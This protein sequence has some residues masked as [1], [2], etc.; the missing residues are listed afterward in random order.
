MKYGLVIYK[1]TDN[2]GDDIL[3]YAAS[4]F[5]P[6]VDYIIDREQLDIFA[7]IEKEKVSV[8]MNGWFLYHKSHWP[9]SPYINPLFIGI[10]FSDKLSFGI[11]DSYLDGAGT[12][13]LKTHGPIGCRD[14]ATLHKMQIRNIQAYFSG[15]LTLT[16]NKFSDVK[17][18]NKFI[19]V[20]V[21]E[22]VY[23][24]V[25]SN[26]D[27]NQV[28]VM[29]HDVD[30]SYNKQEWRTRSAQVE[31]LLKKYQGAGMVITT[32][33]H[34]A[35]PCIALGT[36]VLLLINDNADTQARMGSFKKY[37]HNCTIKEFLNDEIN[38]K[39]KFSNPD[40]YLEIRKQ[41]IDI[42]TDFVE[43]TKIEGLDKLPDLNTFIQYW[44]KPTEWQRMLP[45]DTVLNISKSEWNELIESKRWLEGQLISKNNRIQE[46]KASLDEIQQGKKWL[47]EHSK[48]QEKYIVEL[49]K[50]LEELERGKKWLEKHSA[51]QEKYI[52][53][54][55]KGDC[56][57]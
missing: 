18:N 7:P 32:R 24:K 17:K 21:P 26:I 49:K 6:H 29:T 8:I 31:L 3:S 43:N 10:H 22:N 55:Q 25:L 27:E 51:Q 40:R 42:C 56:D 16:L 5:L 23:Q 37:V 33:L 14:D 28:E 50:W 4:R 36:P 41:L 20:D 30:C 19:L 2:I 52:N 1:D 12:D 57:G 44:K 9:P 34:C 54:L 39:E 13:Y 48:E 35:L 38:W 46:L 47:E 45:T 15:C 11:I 53:E